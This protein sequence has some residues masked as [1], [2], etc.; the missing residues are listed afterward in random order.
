MTVN[1]AAASP[2]DRK[3]NP[4]P[5]Y[6]API[7]A[8]ATYLNTTTVSS[9]MT[10]T[11][12]TTIIEVSVSGGIPAGLKWISRTDTTASVVTVVPTNYD[13]IIPPNTVRRFVVPIEQQGVSS[14]VG[15][16]KQAGLYNRFAVK[17]VSTASS[18]AS[19]WVS[20]F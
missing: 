2:N 7:T 18:V 3:N 4:M 17:G 9:V 5:E 20:E 10:M 15:I 1:Y 11:D 8:K 14:I 6:P 13:H 16:N 12:D 19:I